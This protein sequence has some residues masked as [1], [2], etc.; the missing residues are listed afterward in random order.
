MS[1]HGRAPVRSRI[2][3]TRKTQRRRVPAV[4]NLPRASD[5]KATN[6]VAPTLAELRL[7]RAEILRLAQALGI[8]NV[9]VFGSVARG[10]AIPES[11]VDFLVDLE[12]I[13]SGFEAFGRLEDLRRA[14][15]TL[16]GRKVDVVRAGGLTKMR[17][18]VLAEA[19]PL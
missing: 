15:E 8:S 2:S 12:E 18:R 4:A 6:V 16:L 9:R 10:D 19:V 13:A 11:D 5:Q 17:D 1:R 7:K 14:L 3:G